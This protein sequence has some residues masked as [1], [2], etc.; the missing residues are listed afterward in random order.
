MEAIVKY[1]KKRKFV[2]TSGIF[3]QNNNIDFDK[4]KTS[5]K[6]IHWFSPTGETEFILT[7]EFEIIR[8]G[9]FPVTING[10]NWT[11]NTNE[12]GLHIAFIDIDKLVNI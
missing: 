6:I 5:E 9:V 10:C 11:L 2:N 7:P 12:T 8:R 4:L 3:I 1:I